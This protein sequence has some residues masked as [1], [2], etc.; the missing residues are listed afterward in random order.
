MNAITNKK[1][2]KAD[3]GLINLTGDVSK[4]VDTVMSIQGILSTLTPAQEK[5]IAQAIFEFGLKM[6]SP[7]I[8]I[9][10]M[11]DYPGLNTEHIKSHL[12]KYRIHHERSKRDFSSNYDNVFSNQMKFFREMDVEDL[13]SLVVDHINMALNTGTDTQ[14]SSNSNKRKKPSPDTEEGKDTSTHSTGSNNSSNN[15]AEQ[16]T[17]DLLHESESIL[18]EWRQLC[19]EML[20]RN[21]SLHR[22]LLYL[23]SLEGGVVAER[24]SLNSTTTTKN[25]V[26]DSL[27]GDSNNETIA[28]KAKAMQSDV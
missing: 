1:K 26:Q 21:E 17:I 13:S 14:S 24:E 18:F 27:S 23:C 7:K 16:S 19:L 10:F 9:P 5:I 22:D 8:L 15:Q 25:N 11:P 4:D 6:S 28:L 20:N 2:R 12:Q 3:K